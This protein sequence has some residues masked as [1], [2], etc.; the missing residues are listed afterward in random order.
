MRQ[1]G[2]TLIELMVVI[3]IIGILVAIAL[4]NFVGAQE[5]ARLGNVKS[6][7]HVMQIIMETYAADWSGSYPANEME[8]ENAGRTRGY[9][10]DLTN[11][12]T[13]NTDWYVPMASGDSNLP[14]G[15][16]GLQLNAPLYYW[17]YGGDR[18]GKFLTNKGQNLVFSNS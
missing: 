11:P 12:F 17:I 15:K 5:R 14:Q 4:P 9:W 6:N 2:F 8:L 3:V 13:G 10:K 18:T 1:Q 7:M 16:V